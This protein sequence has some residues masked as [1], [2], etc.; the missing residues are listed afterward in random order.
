[1]NVEKS[2]HFEGVTIP[3]IAQGKNIDNL[4]GQIDKAFLS[5]LEERESKHPNHPNYVLT[6]LGPIAS[7]GRLGVRRSVF[8][9]FKIQVDR[10]CDEC[11]CEQ[12]KQEVA[13]LKKSLRNY[14]IEDEVKQP[15]INNEKARQL[16]EFNVKVINGRY[17]IQ[18]LSK[19][20]V[21]NNFPDNSFA[22]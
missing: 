18:V 22:L 5:V 13:G 9:N 14:E 21:V 8:K 7:G 2:E 17:K 20:Y 10:D 3:V 15:S 6:R 19:K 4:I 1:M 16:V 11:E 12:I